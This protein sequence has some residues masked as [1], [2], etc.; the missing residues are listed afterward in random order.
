MTVIMLWGDSK[1]YCNAPTIIDYYFGEYD[2]A[3]TDDYTDEWL[4]NNTASLIHSCL[5]IVHS[6][7]VTNED[8]LKE[9]EFNALRNKVEKT[10]QLLYCLEAALN[11]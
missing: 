10:R 11:D 8:I 6:Y 5:E 7:Y 2:A 1:R 3:T 9:A 4:K